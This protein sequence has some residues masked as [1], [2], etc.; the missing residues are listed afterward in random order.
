MVRASFHSSNGIKTLLYKKVF[1]Y[2][3]PVVAVIYFVICFHYITTIEDDQENPVNVPYDA[4]GSMLLSFN[5]SVPE[6][7]RCAI[8]LW[9]LPRSFKSIVLPSL[10][11][12]VIVPNAKY[13]CDYFVHFYELDYEE[14]GRA[15]A[16]GKI[17]STEIYQL[18]DKVEE[19][20]R[21]LSMPV[22]PVVKF[23]STTEENFWTEYHDLIEKVRN[24]KDENGNL[25][26][27][28]FN[29]K[30]YEFPKTMDNIV[31][32]W[33]T[34]QSSWNLMDS[35]SNEN[36]I[37]YEQVAMIRS[38]VMYVTSVDIFDGGCEHNRCPIKNYSNLGVIPPFQHP[39]D[40]VVIP[41]FARWKRNDRMIYGPYDAVKIWSTTRFENLD[42]HVQFIKGVRYGFGMHSESFVEYN[43]LPNIGSKGYQIVEHSH[44]CFFRVRVDESVWW[45]DCA[46][47][48]LK[49]VAA[50]FRSR[51]RK[52]KI[53]ENILGRPCRSIFMTKSLQSKDTA[54]NCAIA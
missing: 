19:V 42:E 48:A 34:I 32:M 8:C 53:I 2:F 25:L 9:G 23:T 43:L 27:Y 26:Y 3:L 29:Q 39:S 51:R 4:K 20:A 40:K 37:R 38:D 54:L 52:R 36:N 1:L 47:Q 15:G 30:S 10:V 16:G 12:N 14:A 18:R 35:F 13:Q 24:I 5:S 44:L 21:N 46:V 7:R 49:T 45:D 28:P 41:G 22:L 6:M 17:N 33:H 11:K 31:K 50:P